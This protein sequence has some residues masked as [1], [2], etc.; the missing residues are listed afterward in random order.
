MR[1][2][3][4]KALIARVV[5]AIMTVQLLSG[6]SEQWI[7]L[8]T[9]HF[10]LYTTA[11]EKK[12]REAILYFEE[13][14]TFFRQASSAQKELAPV[15]IVA[16]NSEGQYKPYRMNEGSV[17]YYA[18]NRSREFIVMQDT[19]TD[20]YPGAIHE[21]THLIVQRDGLK[22]P[23]WFNEGWAELFSS[24][25]PMGNKVMVGKVLPG[26]AQV[27]LTTK[28]LDLSVLAAVNENSNLYNERDKAGIFYAES[29][30]LV[31]ML[32]LSAPYRPDFTK[33]IAA[34]ASGQDTAQAFHSVY[35]KE[36]KDVQQDLQ[37]YVK[38]DRLS[39]AVYDIKLE[40]SDED[41]EVSAVP[42]AESALV[43]ADLLALIHHSDEARR[44]YGQLLK[45]NPENGD[46]LESLGYFAGQTGDW[47]G[48]REYFSRALK[49]GT[50][51][52]QLCYDYAMLVAQKDSSSQELVPIL[53]RAV[54]LNPDYVD[55]R[56]Q[57]GLTLT[58]QQ[59]YK[60]PGEELRQIKK[61]T[62]EQAPAYF[63]ALA[64][65]DFN[66]GR[67]DQARQNAESAKKWAK[68]PADSE[69]AESIL[70][71]LDAPKPAPVQAPPVQTAQVPSQATPSATATRSTELVPKTGD[72]PDRPTLRHRDQPPLTVQ[73][74][75][76]RNPFVKPDDHMIHVE[77]TAQKLDCAGESARFYV[78]VGSRTMVFEIPDPTSVL[79]KHPGESH[80]DFAC[81]IQ[82]PFP[83]AIDYAEKADAKKGTAGIVREL[84]F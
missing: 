82:K 12:G 34:L 1:Y 63:L 13:V 40:K 56:F 25:Q 28:W 60:E 36:L 75:A 5:F 53:R 29:W 73:Q 76:P 62:P 68:D 66:T 58:N 70:R 55:A 72:D 42:P 14:R 24:L 21:F 23:T 67:K 10:I 71:A 39:A 15:R 41:P 27:L 46:V 33:F 54:E 64:I 11:G 20:H 31:H 6:A 69:Q 57:L 45:E 2:F 16:F 4:A 3:L 47:D 48:A 79:I 65:S 84:D 59:S 37:R 77:G 7:K 38:S 19:A 43:L 49:A 81:G 9:P 61:V 22:L 83:V 51:N 18:L 50:K 17:A 52:P 78:Q 32:Q 35:G 80:H 8:E 74:N 26:R 44:A 30:L